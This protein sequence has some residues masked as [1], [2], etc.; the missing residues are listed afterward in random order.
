[1]NIASNL[2][3]DPIKHKYSDGTQNNYTS[4]TTIIGKYEHKFSDKEVEISKACAKIGKNP[5][6]PKFLKYKGKTYKQILAEWKEEGDRARE[7]GNETHDF[8]ETN[9]NEANG[10]GIFKKKLTG[11][12]IYT[13]LDILNNP[14]YGKVDLELFKQYKIDEIYPDIYKL[15]KI[16]VD[17]GWEIYAEIGVHSPAFL[18]SG[19]IDILVV[20][21]KEFYIVDWKTNKHE[22]K[23]EA[24]YWDRDHN[25][26]ILGY[27]KTNEFLKYPLDAVPAST[28]YKYGL[29]L[30]TYAFLVEQYGLKWVGS[31]LCHIRHHTYEHGDRKVKNNPDM[32]GKT[33]VNIH[34]IKYMKDYV[35]LMLNDNLLVNN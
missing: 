11:G 13:I 31:Y 9:V 17:K 23:Y 32:L 14:K 22:M 35:Q 21:G 12:R 16:F 6:H 30:S 28:G 20:K 7:K 18:V 10:Y 29:Q 15:I 4:V 2:Y 34:P 24:G 33:V 5:A 19:L 27:I 1:M 26:N 3:F 25:K 8:L